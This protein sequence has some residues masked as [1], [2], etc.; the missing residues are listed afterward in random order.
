MISAH[1][2]VTPCA[3]SEASRRT[4]C[5]QMFFVVNRVALLLFAS[6][7]LVFL[8]V[9]SHLHHVHYDPLNWSIQEL[10]PLQLASSPNALVIDARG[11]EAYSQDGISGAFR[12][13][14]NSWDED[15]MVFIN[16]WRL[17]R[18]VI[19]YCDN[20]SCG[21]SR[22]ITLRLMRELPEINIY[23]LKGGLTA[24]NAY[25]ETIPLL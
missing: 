17:E 4:P 18:I 12:L 25:Q 16:E 9:V 19:V 10:T 11:G 3:T 21:S 2:R 15:L 22:R 5:V 1:M 23:I 14:E 8:L 13:S 20:Q 6:C 24:W 7:G